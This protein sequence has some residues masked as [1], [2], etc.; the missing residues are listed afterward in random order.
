MSMF[1]SKVQNSLNDNLAV[2]LESCADFF[3]QLV[4][5][6]P[7]LGFSLSTHLLSLFDVCL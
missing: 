4:R 2:S 5:Y 1:L 7:Y 3:S 6:V